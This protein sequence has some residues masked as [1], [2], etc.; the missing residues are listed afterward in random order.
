LAAFRIDTTAVTNRAYQEFVDDGGY[1]DP[2]H[3]SD[4]GW[5]WRR[6]AGLVTPQFWC[7]GAGGSWSRRRYGRVEPVPPDEP[8]QHVCWYEADA[9]ARWFGARLPTEA[10][11]EVAARGTPLPAANLWQEGPHRF[12]PA[13]VG[14]RPGDVSAWGAH[15]MLGGVW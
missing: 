10:E 4:A 14:S 3:W 6:E 11:W 2:T 5:A 1:D 9:Y 12:A 8:V 13:P 15:G 7:P